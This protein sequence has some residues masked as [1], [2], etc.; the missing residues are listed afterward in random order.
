MHR[1]N[2][3]AEFQLRLEALR[4]RLKNKRNLQKLAEARRRTLYL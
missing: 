4:R 2:R 1:L 3:S